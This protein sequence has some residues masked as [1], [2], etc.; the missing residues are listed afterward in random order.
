MFYFLH[1]EAASP[2][3]ARYT[4][5]IHCCNHSN[6]QCKMLYKKTQRHACSTMLNPSSYYSYKTSYKFNKRRNQ[7]NEKK[8]KQST[9]KISRVFV[10]HGE[11]QTS[12]S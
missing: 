3:E 6:Q 9:V 7:N 8:K 11:G 12:N 1:I 4:G 2:I 5:S 10:M